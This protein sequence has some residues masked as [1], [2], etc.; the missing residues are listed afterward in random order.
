MTFGD[1]PLGPLSED[2]KFYNPS[3][4]FNLIGFVLFLIAVLI[5]VNSC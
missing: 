1:E 4:A 5:L 2:L 3:C